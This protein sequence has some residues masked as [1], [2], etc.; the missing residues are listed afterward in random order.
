M[1][2]EPKRRA[3]INL[4]GLISPVA[5]AVGLVCALVGLLSDKQALTWASLACLVLTLAFIKYS[6]RLFGWTRE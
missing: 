4:L 6:N 2:S 1:E 5:A 3:R